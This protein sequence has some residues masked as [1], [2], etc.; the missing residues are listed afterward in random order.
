MVLDEAKP[1]VPSEGREMGRKVQRNKDDV[2]DV[3]P[4]RKAKKEICKTKT[5]SLSVMDKRGIAGKVVKI[6][7]VLRS[8]GARARGTREPARNVNRDVEVE[9]VFLVSDLPPGWK[10]VVTGRV[11]QLVTAGG[12]RLTSQV[13]CQHQ[14][15]HEV[16][17]CGMQ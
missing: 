1:V 14:L 11:R 7:E 13:N 15:W 2:A 3:M 5:K 10:R 9:E 8:I 4:N 12:L 16:I 17:R 6:Q